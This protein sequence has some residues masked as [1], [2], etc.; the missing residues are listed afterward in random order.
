MSY[1]ELG[2]LVRSAGARS[3]ATRYLT[4]AR[5]HVRIGR[6]EPRAGGARVRTRGGARPLRPAS[7]V[8]VQ[9]DG[10][11]ALVRRI[12]DAAAMPALLA[13]EGATALLE[14]CDAQAAVVFV[15]PDPGQV[16]VLA[17]A[18]C[19][20]DSAQALALA[21]IR[22]VRRPQAPLVIDGAA[23]PRRRGPRFAV[24]PR[25]GL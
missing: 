8:G 17:F 4:D 24:I 15:Q 21:A 1:L 7:Y 2:R 19:S 16:R 5:R 14:V 3:R 25:P 6:R 11:D 22:A 23:R 12:V 20:D 10:D 9:M 18:G 13:R